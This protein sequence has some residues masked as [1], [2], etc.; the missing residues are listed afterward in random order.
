MIWIASGLWKSS[1]RK[2]SFGFAPKKPRPV[3]LSGSHRERGYRNGSLNGVVCRIG[4]PRLGGA[5]LIVSAPSSARYAA[6]E[7]P[8][9]YCVVETH[10][11]PFMTSGLSYRFVV[12]NTV[13]QKSSN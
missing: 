12:S 8:R 9:M 10:R 5:T 1:D 13:R 7:G 3:P 6:Q 4:S 11:I 2:Y